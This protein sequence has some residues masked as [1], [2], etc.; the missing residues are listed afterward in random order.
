MIEICGV[1]FA[2]VLVII[3]AALHQKPPLGGDDE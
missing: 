3:A 2:S 1:I